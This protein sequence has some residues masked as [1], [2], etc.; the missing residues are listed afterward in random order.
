MLLLNLIS[1][2]AAFTSGAQALYM[3]PSDAGSLTKRGKTTTGGNAIGKTA[4]FV[5]NILDL[6]DF[7]NYKYNVIYPMSNEL[8]Y[9][10][11][12]YGLRNEPKTRYP[13]PHYDEIKH[14]P[15]FNWSYQ[16][17]R[18]IKDKQ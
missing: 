16:I 6:Y 7:Q 12:P 8:G 15:E 9:R 10:L 4:N 18:C 2:V 5:G 14:W 11:E 13:G 17:S 1:T 3:P